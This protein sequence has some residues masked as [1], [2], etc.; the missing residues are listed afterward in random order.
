MIRRRWKLIQISVRLI[1]RR[2]TAQHRPVSSFVRVFALLCGILV[3]LSGVR[4]VSGWR[5]RRR[6]RKLP[7]TGTLAGPRRILPSIPW[8]LVTNVWNASAAVIVLTVLTGT[9]VADADP[10]GNNPAKIALQNQ[11]SGTA[12]PP[13]PEN[14]STRLSGRI[15]MMLQIAMLEHSLTRLEQVDSYTTRFEKQERIDGELLEP[16]IL[17]A[18]IRHQPFSVYFK[19]EAGPVG[20]EILFPVSAE[21]PRLLVKSARLGGRLPAMKLDPNSTIVMSET[22]Y[23]ITMAGIK[24]LAKMTLEVRQRD[25]RRPEK[26]VAIELRDDVRF[27]NRPVYAYTVDYGNPEISPT[28][29]RC[30]LYIDKQLMV[31]VY[32]RNWTWASE[33]PEGNPDTF[34]DTTLIEYY[35]FRKVDIHA[36]LK[37]IDF[38]RENTEYNLR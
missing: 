9:L 30:V 27:D 24:E 6:L 23:P 31:P 32:V 12:A 19:F 8:H 5:S 21:D 17:A 22:R 2:L 18:K 7:G 13:Q 20:Q 1:W 34:D 38:A 25:I 26:S 28:Y 35:A 4:Y 11:Q 10:I 36:T 15:A 14:K 3:R 16:Q 33:V 29:R 37:S